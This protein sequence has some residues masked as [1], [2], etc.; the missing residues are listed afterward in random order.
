MVH[1]LRNRGASGAGLAK[2][3]AA[4]VLLCLG[5]AACDD[6]GISDSARPPVPTNLTVTVIDASTLRLDWQGS[7]QVTA[8]VVQRRV[9]GQNFATVGEPTDT[10]FTDTGLD[11]DV[12][13]EYRVAARR[14]R[15]T[16]S[17]SS[18]VSGVPEDI[19]DLTFAADLQPLNDVSVIGDTIPIT[20]VTGEAT[21]EITEG[22][23]TAQVTAT[24]LAPGIAHA[25][26]IRTGSGCPTPA[27]D[28]NDDA[29]VDVIEGEPFFGRILVP[30]DAD[31][32]T[33]AG[34]MDQFPVANSLGE[35]D[36]SEEADFDELLADLTAEDPDPDDQIVKL[37]GD[38]LELEGLQ[39]VLHGVDSTEVTLPTSVQ[40][41]PGTS[42]YAT[43]PVAC[44]EIQLIS[45]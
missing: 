32:R 7:S 17:F 18:V 14:G 35:I 20:P 29:F 1:G 28:T 27:A 30:L 13:Y 42:R 37:E 43:L 45:D 22:N 5:L 6:D 8:Y 23:F 10:T 2:S 16:S 39:V 3:L 9:V 31:L 21:F 19:L 33:Q 4:A 44:G 15:I 36:Y 24:G 26:H 11:E 25:Q 38:S 41:F 12:V 34:G 40:T